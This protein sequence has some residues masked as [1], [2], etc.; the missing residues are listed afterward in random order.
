MVDF[1]G[2]TRR[3]IY[4]R[5]RGGRLSLTNLMSAHCG[6]SKMT[7]RLVCFSVLHLP[8]GPPSRSHYQPRSP[9]I[10]PSRPLSLEASSAILAL[11]PASSPTS[12]GTI[13]SSDP[14][15][16]RSL[17]TSFIIRVGED[18]CGELGSSTNIREVSFSSDQEEE[19]RIELSTVYVLP[20]HS[21]TKV[22]IYIVGY[23][24]C[25]ANWINFIVSKDRRNSHGSICSKE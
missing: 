10:L 6:I 22:Y 17:K 11:G 24:N 19:G 25:V 12:R 16:S 21:S 3:D 13:A 7:R 23:E 14:S 9:A 2:R 5:M 1:E 8:P 15:G 18:S 4:S 20:N